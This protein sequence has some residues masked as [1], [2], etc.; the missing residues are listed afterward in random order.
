MFAKLLKYE[1]KSTSSILGILSLCVLC[2]AFL[3]GGAMRFLIFCTEK[4]AMGE[5]PYAIPV[6][7]MGLLLVGVVLAIVAYA[8]G[9]Q[10]LLYFRFYKSHFTD[11]GY[12]TFTLPVTAAEIFWSSFLVILGWMVIIPATASG[13]NGPPVLISSPEE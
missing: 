1:W 11:E 8:V 13:R 9:S 10:I 5:D 6:F 12:L 2:V 3:G 4:V 7:L